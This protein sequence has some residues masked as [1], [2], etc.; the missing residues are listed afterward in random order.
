MSNNNGRKLTGKVA[1]VTGGSA[2]NC[3]AVCSAGLPLMTVSTQFITVTPVALISAAASSG[4][5]R[6]VG[7]EYYDIAEKIKFMDAHRIDISV[8]SLANPWLDWVPQ[9]EAAKARRG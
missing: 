7:A 3:V 2:N 1:M 5:G 4:S 9:A 6:P 8:I